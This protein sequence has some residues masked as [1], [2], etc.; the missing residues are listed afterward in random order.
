M[1]IETIQERLQTLSDYINDI[2]CICQLSTQG[3]IIGIENDIWKMTK[4][5][6]KALAWVVKIL[7]AKREELKKLLEKKLICMENGDNL[8][9]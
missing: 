6:K 4:E 9:K 7:R 3:E 5:Q 2:D 8:L 1:K